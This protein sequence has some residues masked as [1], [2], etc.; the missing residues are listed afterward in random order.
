[1][2]VAKKK[3]AKPKKVVKKVVNKK[4]V[5]TAKPKG[6]TERLGLI[7]VGGKPATVLGDDVKVGQKAPEFN[8]QANDWSPVS[9]L[10]ATAGKVRILAAMPSLSTGTCDKETRTFNE[11]A[12]ELGDDIQ[13]L[14]ITTDLPPTQKVWC[15]AAGVERVSTYSD[16][17]D[18]DFGIKYGTA[19][20]ERRWHRRA[21]FV[22]DKNDTITYAAYMPALGV[23]PNYDEVLAAAKSA[24]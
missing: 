4:V 8:V 24:I 5:R 1:M 23:E 9:G 7:E 18:F 2:A 6:P 22:V 17:M 16:H 20:K 13:V 10:A 15:A 12:A 14:V 3:A 19:I 21:V 11:R